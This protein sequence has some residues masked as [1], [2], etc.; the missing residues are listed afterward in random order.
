[1]QGLGV[2]GTHRVGK[3]TLVKKWAKKNDIEF[4]PLDVSGVI[5]QTV[6]TYCDGVNDLDTRLTAQRA[7]VDACHERFMYR[8]TPFITDRTPMDVAA[9][10]MADMMQGSM[11]DDQ[12]A[13]AME[14]IESCID[15]TNFAFTGMVLLFPS[16]HIPFKPVETSAAPNI[17]YQWHIHYLIH[18]ILND[19]RVDTSFWYMGP[20]IHK[21]KDRMSAMDAI[22]EALIEDDVELAQQLVLN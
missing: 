11:T 22:Y 2:C 4:I 8:R 21:L 1:M 15:I 9:Y 5:K 14:I 17:P 10:T 18:G 12:Q 13:E 3:S 20:D 7:L 6:G 19:P 16:E